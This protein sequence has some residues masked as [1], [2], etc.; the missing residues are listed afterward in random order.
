MMVVQKA[1]N[2]VELWAMTMGV[3]MVEGKATNWV[4]TMAVLMGN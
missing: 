2:L 3:K 1:L 4:G